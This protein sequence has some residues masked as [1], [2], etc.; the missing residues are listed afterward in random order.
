[1]LERMK[2][3]KAFV[4]RRTELSETSMK[5]FLGLFSI[6]KYKKGDVLHKTGEAS[7]KFFFLEKGMA[8]SVIV[9]SSGHKKTRSFFTE[10]T[11]FT[12]HI[13]TLHNE[14]INAE[15]D[16]LIESIIYEG[17]FVNFIELTYKYHDISILY[18]K[19]LEESFLNMKE[20]ATILSTLNATERYL[21]L[22]EQFPEIES[23]IQ[24]NH[25][26]SYLSITP[27]QLSRIR[28]K[29]YS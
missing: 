28:R 1:M 9:D 12:S 13:S 22:K 6:K 11:M 15:F 19:I 8:R 27:I 10:N 25:I 17:D 20:K 21:Y 5:A 2:S 14:P 7:R 3:I 4:S 26:A 18:N 29:L 23:L 16:C 24:L